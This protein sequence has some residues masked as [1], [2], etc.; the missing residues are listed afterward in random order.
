MKH[1]ITS[2]RD[3]EECYSNEIWER[4]KE[5]WRRRVTRGNDKARL[6]GVT[7]VVN[8]WRSIMVKESDG[9][10]RLV[11]CKESEKANRH[12]KAKKK[13][14]TWE[15]VTFNGTGGGRRECR[16]RTKPSQESEKDE[17]EWQ[18]SDKNKGQNK[19]IRKSGVEVCDTRQRGK[20]VKRQSLYSK[21][22]SLFNF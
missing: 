11:S 6:K 3:R 5:L 7:L 17:S 14:K 18:S 13:Q 8:E 9:A 22:I 20:R 2:K 19:T 12:G 10:K 1:E 15:G 21:C 4:D 16:V